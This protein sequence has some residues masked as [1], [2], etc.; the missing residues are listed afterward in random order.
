M[1]ANP[2]YRLIQGVCYGGLAWI[3]SLSAAPLSAEDEIRFVMANAR[4]VLLHEIGHLLIN[5]LQ[6]PVL[7]REED[8]ADQLGFSAF[9]VLPD[10]RDDPNLSRYLL[11]IANYWRLESHIS[12]NTPS[13]RVAVWDS[14]PLDIQR[15]YNLACL[16]YGSDP[17]NM[18]WLLKA[19]GLPVER[20]LYCDTEYNQ[21]LNALHWTKTHY[22]RDKNT[23]KTPIKVRYEAIPHQL[24]AETRFIEKVRLSGEIEAIAAR[25]SSDFA[26]PRPLTIEARSCGA[27][28]AW[29]NRNVGELTLCYEYLLL[30]RDHARERPDLLNTD[31]GRHQH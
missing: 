27:A 16:A 7:G 21:A 19:T 24:K 11:D 28:D 2:L 29:F 31:P 3:C 10:Y 18:S 1:P 5:E 15:F 9:F 12:Q 14:H 22:R 6:L 30:F 17:Q 26:L 13:Q 23:T 25:I 8:A 4:F 20:A